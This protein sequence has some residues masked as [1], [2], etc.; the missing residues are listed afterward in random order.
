ME[1]LRVSFKVERYE[2][3][4]ACTSKLS[5][6]YKYDTEAATQ[7]IFKYLTLHRGLL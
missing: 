4:K 1:V 6:R 3:Q 7:S 2:P 5:E